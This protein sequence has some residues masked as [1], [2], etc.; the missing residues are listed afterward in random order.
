LVPGGFRFMILFQ[1]QSQIS[2]IFIVAL[3]TDRLQIYFIELGLDRHLLVAGGAGE[4]V[5]APGL[6]ESR[7]HVALD[8]L[9]ADVAK[10]SEQLMIVSL[11]VCQTFS[12]IMTIAEERFLTL[13][14]DKVFHA[15]V[16]PQGRDHPVLD[17]PPAGSTDG[18]PHLVVAAETVELVEFLGGVAWPGPHLP[19]CAGQL[20]ATPSAVEVVWAIIL[21]SEPQR[22]PINGRVALLTH[23]LPLTSRFYLGITFMT[24]S[25]ALI[26]DEAKICQ[27]LMTHLTTETLRV[28]SRSHRLDD[29]SDD[30]LPALGAAGSVEDVE[31][32]FAIFPVLKLVEHSIWELSEALGT[33]KAARA[34][35]LPIA[36]HYFGFWFESIFT[37]STGYAVEVHNSWHDQ[38]LRPGPGL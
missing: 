3:L 8:H 35:Q 12:L 18:D 25:S 26:L 1:S 5:D 2:G 7:E 11:A 37:A 17:G 19:G 6:V 9:V 36:V 15:P 31:A 13:G 10:V 32:M 22:L 29:P 30:E 38:R 27:F 21:S 24:E 20:N 33:D 14:A 4:V 34:V 23:V 28:P 16:F